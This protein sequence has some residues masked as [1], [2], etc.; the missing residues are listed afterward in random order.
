[1]FKRTTAINKLLK[2]TKRKRVIQGGTW[3]GKTY[4]IIPII[5]DHCAKNKGESY[6]I[7]AESIPALKKGALKDFIEIMKI[8]N[9][10]IEDNYNMTDRKYTF[11]N[12]SYIEFSSF[13][14]VGDAQAAGKR[15]GLFINE[16]P[17]ISFGIADA[18]M[19]RTSGF[20][21]VDFNPTR[22]FWAHEELVKED[23]TDFIILT[24]KD[25][26]GLPQSIMD[27]LMRKREKAKTSKYWRNWCAV[28]LDGEIGML[29]GVIFQEGINWEI[30]EEIPAEAE[31]DGCGLDFGYSNDPTALIGSHKWNGAKV[32]DELIYKT[33]LLN[34]H[35]YNEIIEQGIDINKLIVAESA[36]PK[37]IEDLIQMGLNVIPAVKGKDSINNGIAK[38]QENKFYITSRSTNVIRELRNYSWKI[39]KDGNSLNIPIDDYNHGIDAIR[40]KESDNNHEFWVY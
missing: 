33:R 25:N 39:D 22:R 31:F 34:S 7:V 15:T 32:Y 8:T 1:M 24:Y 3:A 36:E 20:I 18:L 28:Y 4:G 6:T 27:D 23:D 12:G 26:E 17:Y 5:I 9:R 16:A 10:W 21:W 40:Y 19:V 11:S 14:S 37:S 13:K 38:M 30:I 2:L 35:I 29:E